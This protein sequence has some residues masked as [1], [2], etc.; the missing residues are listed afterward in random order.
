[1]RAVLA[2]DSGGT[3]CN[4]VLVRDDGEVLGLGLCDVSD[5]C[6]GRGW[7]GSGRSLESV[8]HASRQALGGT[9]W[10][11]LHVAN[12]NHAGISF[13]EYADA[14][15]HHS[16]SEQGAAFALAGERHGIVVLAGTG[17]FVHGEAVD[18]RQCHLDSLGPLL[19]DH[20]SGYHIGYLGIRAAAKALWHPRHHTSLSGVLRRAC[21]AD[22]G[23]VSG[24]SLIPF[25]RRDPDRAEVAALAKLVDAEANAGDRI[26]IGILHEAAEAIAETVRDVVDNLGMAGSDHPMVGTGSVATNCRIYWQH[27]SERVAQFAPRLRP[28]RMHRPQVLGI[29]LEVLRELG[30]VPEQQFRETIF[31]SYDERISEQ[32]KGISA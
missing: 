2:I 9:H 22:E 28:V 12:L 11:E 21:G 6:A 32:G 14:I 1:M 13:A 19:G 26:S 20:G 30:A 3:K 4:A 24:Y 8:L 29:A 18:G 16:V 25:S 5:Q 27:L 23:D 10:D 17:A 7:G 31:R 15:A